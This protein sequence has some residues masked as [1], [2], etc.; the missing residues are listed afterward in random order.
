MKIILLLSVLG[1]CGC[2]APAKN[3]TAEKKPAPAPAAPQL[4]DGIPVVEAHP[5]REIKFDEN[6]HPYEVLKEHERL[7]ENC[8]K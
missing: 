7:C 3:K 6:G 8:D 5:K 1:I 4:I 2:A